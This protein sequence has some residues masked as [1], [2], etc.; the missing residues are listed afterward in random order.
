MTLAAIWGL[1]A[2]AMLLALLIGPM[3]RAAVWIGMLA[4]MGTACVAN[5]RRCGR[6]HCRYTGPFFLVMAGLVAVYIAGL[7]PLGSQPWLVLAMLIGGGN[8]L[9]WSSSERYLG[10]YL[11]RD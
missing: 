2:V 9:I 4:L 1:P 8:A 11:P 5:T 3:W 6:T 10:T 7:V